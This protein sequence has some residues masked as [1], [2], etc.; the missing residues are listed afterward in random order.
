MSSVKHWNTL[1]WISVGAKLSTNVEVTLFSPVEVLPGLKLGPRLFLLPMNMFKFDNSYSETKALVRVLEHLKKGSSID[2][3][4]NPYVRSWKPRKGQVSP[5]EG[6]DPTQPPY[7]Y[8]QSPATLSRLLLV[9][10]VVI[11][12]APILTLVLGLL[13]NLLFGR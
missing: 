13:L 12:V 5:P 10:A 3:H 7:A 6:W 11:V 4:P 8:T 9:F 1:A 2:L